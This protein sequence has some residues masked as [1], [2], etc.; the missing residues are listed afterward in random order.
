MQIIIIF[1]M[2]KGHFDFSLQYSNLNNS[3]WRS[4]IEKTISGYAR[5]VDNAKL[6][7]T[8]PSGIAGNYF[9]HLTHNPQLIIP[10]TLLLISC[11]INIK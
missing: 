2:L 10:L 4:G 7:V 1:Y 9:K 3:I 11:Q 8:F 6:A 5:A